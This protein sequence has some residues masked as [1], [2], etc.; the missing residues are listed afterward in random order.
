MLADAEGDF[1]FRVPGL[2]ISARFIV[3]ATRAA[4]YRP[5]TKQ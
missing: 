2:K 1:A 5:W 3:P 4:N